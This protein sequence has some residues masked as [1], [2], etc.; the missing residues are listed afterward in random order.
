[1]CFSV[2]GFCYGTEVKAF[3]LVQ[4]P[5]SSTF[6]IENRDA[7][8]T[9]RAL[10]THLNRMQ[11]L[12]LVKQISDF[13]LLLFLAGVLDLNSDVPALA[14]CVLTQTTVPEGYKLLINSMAE[15]A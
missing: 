8:V 4:G 13:H 5:L 9:M 7:K 11:S 1:M 6:P 15:T 10:K 2:L 14:Q 12:P 3:I